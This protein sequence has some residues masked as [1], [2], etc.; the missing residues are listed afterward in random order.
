MALLVLWFRVTRLLRLGASSRQP[1]SAHTLSEDA[2]SLRPV[3]WIYQNTL[4]A[5]VDDVSTTFRSLVLIDFHKT[6]PKG[7]GRHR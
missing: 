4:A 1:L 7:C 3:S 2:G 6:G 5:F